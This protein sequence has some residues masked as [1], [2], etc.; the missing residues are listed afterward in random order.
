MA[1]FIKLNINTSSEDISE[2]DYTRLEDLT[3]NGIELLPK[4]EDFPMPWDASCYIEG[5]NFVVEG[6]PGPGRSVGKATVSIPLN[7]VDKYMEVN[8]YTDH[9]E[10]VRDILDKYYWL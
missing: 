9:E 3:Y 5:G 6:A 8:V 10:E 4:N 7:S 2:Q 1:S